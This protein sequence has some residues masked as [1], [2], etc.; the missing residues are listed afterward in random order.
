M[1]CTEPN[2]DL[3]ELAADAAG[4][5]FVAPIIRSVDKAFRRPAPTDETHRR[6]SARNLAEAIVDLA[7]E[8]RVCLAVFVA[9]LNT[10]TAVAIAH[11]NSNISLS[12]M[13][14]GVLVGV[15]GHFQNHIE[16]LRETLASV[17]G[18]TSTSAPPDAAAR[19]GH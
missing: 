8:Q 10:I 9:A 6:D 7:D 2:V 17:I 12:E 14:S 13:R 1:R 3:R 11:M 15:D 18:A 19:K 16:H 5:P 4:N